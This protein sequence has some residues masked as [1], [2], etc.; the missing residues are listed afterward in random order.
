MAN[1][2]EEGETQFYKLWCLR[3]SIK[4]KQYAE[5]KGHAYKKHLYRTELKLLKRSWLCGQRRMYW[6][7]RRRFPIE[8]SKHRIGALMKQKVIVRGT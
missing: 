1:V 5:Y 3:E 6:R 4:R 2:Q 8:V 7:F